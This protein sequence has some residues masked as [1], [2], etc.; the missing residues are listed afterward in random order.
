[1]NL[2][3]VSIIAF[4]IVL[5]IGFK[6]NYN[7]G[8]MAIVAAY[9]VGKAAGMKDGE[10]LSGF[11]STLFILIVG[12][13]FLF[14]IV[15]KTGALDL[16]IKKIISK[17]GKTAPLV[18]VVFFVVFL[19]ITSLG[20]GPYAVMPLNAMLAMTIAPSL[21][22]NPLFLM[23]SGFAGIC[24]GTVSPVS[25]AGLVTADVL[26][27]NGLD[28]SVVPHAYYRSI[29]AFGLVAL[30]YFIYF[31]G[32]KLKRDDSIIVDNLPEFNKEQKLTLV[33]VLI[34]ILLVLIPKYNPGPV[35][36]IIGIILIML[37]IEDE[38]EII[39]SIPWSTT[40]MITGMS[41]LINVMA[42][43]GAIDILSSQLV[44][45]SGS[46][47]LLIIV[48]SL[49]AGIFSVLSTMSSVVIPTLGAMLPALLAATGTGD[50]ML[51]PLVAVIFASGYATS[52]SP[53]SAGGGMHLATLQSSEDPEIR[54]SYGVRQFLELAGIQLVV[55]IVFA[56]IGLFSVPL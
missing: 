35:G 14:A 8:L 4:V 2:A 33:G 6:W 54:D 17:T 51:T 34:F 55:M 16:L 1:M 23:L 10:I 11:P 44:K 26:E 32:W 19:V 47:R 30:I 37:G 48:M 38:K 50:A 27:Q 21:G 25:L 3:W 36:L 5:A 13:M 53:F 28:P 18:P 15:Q 31:K 42:N 43:T 9:F 20:S 7:V 40:L 24:A 29:L 45:V 41:V 12:V 39:K 52:I 22:A 49:V 56:A 46:P